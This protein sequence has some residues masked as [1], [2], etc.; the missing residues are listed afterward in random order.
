MA[1]GQPITKSWTGV[2]H[3]SVGHAWEWVCQCFSM[4]I[5]SDGCLFQLQPVANVEGDQSV[6]ASF[7]V[8]HPAFR[9]L[10][11]STASDGKLGMGLGTKP[12]LSAFIILCHM[13]KT[14]STPV[15]TSLLMSACMMAECGSPGVCIML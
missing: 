13:L 5:L 11:Y 7:P 6:L 2:H 15:I 12:S 9:R 1:L 14:W 8:P 4:S 10:Q 3:S